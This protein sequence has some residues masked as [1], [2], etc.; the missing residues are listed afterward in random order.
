MVS[1]C[2]CDSVQNQSRYCAACG[3]FRLPY[4]S[5]NDIFTTYHFD[6]KFGK[7]NN[8]GE[9][10]PRS[11]NFTDS[12]KSFLHCD[13]YVAVELQNERS[14]KRIQLYFLQDINLTGDGAKEKFEI[15]HNDYKYVCLLRPYL[16]TL[17]AQNLLTFYHFK[18]KSKNKEINLKKYISNNQH[19]IALFSIDDYS[20]EVIK[21]QLLIVTNNSI[22]QVFLTKYFD[23][24]YVKEIRE[25]NL[26]GNS[27]YTLNDYKQKLLN[28][29]I[30]SDKQVI[31]CDYQNSKYLN[32]INIVLNGNELV[33][34]LTFNN[35]DFQIY[36][37]NNIIKV[38]L[39][40]GTGNFT[41]NTNTEIK[42][43]SKPIID[44]KKILFFIKDND[45]V[46]LCYFNFEDKQW[47]IDNDFDRKLREKN[48]ETND[49]INN[50]NLDNTNLSELPS[51]YF[52]INED[53]Y[54]LA[55]IQTQNKLCIYNFRNNII[56]ISY[57]NIPKGNIILT[58]SYLVILTDKSIYTTQR[59]I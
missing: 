3:G 10:H 18:D 53:L 4:N 38:E 30:N 27:I 25:I 56:N 42:K 28:F 54:F 34:Q 44:D 14:E 13:D 16:I 46:K 41:L 6:K 31:Q 15:Q 8:R 5:K 12:I 33:L 52:I 43:I 39:K 49:F 11:K 1:L 37:N 50:I 57:D 29:I 48:I 26:Q 55:T 47:K 32:P 40:S 22:Y 59:P 51:T 7:P 21:S 19:V 9:I 23:L 17:N 36:K 2:Q 35:Y 45:H 20:E 24:E 58:Y